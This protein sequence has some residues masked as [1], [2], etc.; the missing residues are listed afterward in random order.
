MKARRCRHLDVCGCTAFTHGCH[1]TTDL[2]LEMPLL[3]NPRKAVPKHRPDVGEVFLDTL[4]GTN[5]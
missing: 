5:T 2:D 4:F 3:V 1:P